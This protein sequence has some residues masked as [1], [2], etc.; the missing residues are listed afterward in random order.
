MKKD[1]IR[2]PADYVMPSERLKPKAETRPEDYDEWDKRECFL[3]AALVYSVAGFILG[4]A[5][6]FLWFCG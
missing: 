1:N 6:T 5:V 3:G 2:M 4:C